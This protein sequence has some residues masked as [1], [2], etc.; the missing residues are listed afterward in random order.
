MT[1]PPAPP[2]A[3]RDTWLRERNELLVREKQH[4]REGD[5]IA[6]ARRRLPMTEVDGSIQLT[7]AS[8][9]TPLREIFAGRDELVVYKHMFHPGKPLPDQCE[10]CTISLWGVQDTS[11]LNA[12]GITFAV[13][14]EGPYD[15]IAA[16]RDFMGYPHPWYSNHAIDDPAVAGGGV[17][18]CFLRRDDRVYLTYETTNRGVETAIPTLKLL[19]LTAYGRR[20]QWEDSPE[21]WPQEPTYSFWRT[22]AQGNR[23]GLGQGRPTPQWT[24][25]NVT[26]A[27]S[28]TPH[29]CH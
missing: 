13:F 4:T 24:R 26:S 1:I 23:V 11:Y 17:Y 21:G 28:Q 20:E 10:G 3:D 29:H 9:P 6:A 19:D 18:A 12:V 25:P 14:A 15:E 5:T 16:L 2:I 8:G 7:G 22:D 27:T